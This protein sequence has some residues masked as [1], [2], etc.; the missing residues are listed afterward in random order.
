M[1]DE[2]RGA[3][4]GMV[5]GDGCVRIRKRYEE[6]RKE[7]AQALFQCS[8]SIKQ[9]PY[10]EHKRD[11]LNEILGGTAKM[12]YYDAKLK[13]REIPYRMCRFVKANKYFQHLRDW[14]YVDGKKVINT[15]VLDWLSIEGLAYWYLDD[16]CA[17][18]WKRVDGSITSV[19][20]NIAICRPVHECDMFMGWLKENLDV[21][22]KLGYTNNNN[23]VRLK[24]QDAV[25]LFAAVT[26]Y[27]PKSMLYKVNPNYVVHEHQT[28]GKLRTG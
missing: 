11:R 2:E 20:V 3:I 13:G 17:D 15:R 24:T 12:S 28:P 9:L 4:V 8:H 16:G 14:L 25:K 5:M 21:N 27:V 10:A 19:Q 18:W 1:N 7:Q 23:Y 6:H 22:S 26:K